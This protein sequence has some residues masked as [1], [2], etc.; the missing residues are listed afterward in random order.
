VQNKGATASPDRHFILS[1]SPPSAQHKRLA[2]ALVIAIAVAALAIAGPLSR[3]ELPRIDAFVPAYATAM[4]VT[5]LITAILLYAQFSILHSRAILVIASGY[6]FSALILIP[7]ILTFPDALRPGQI[8]GGLQS[9]SWL[10]FLQHACF[11]IFVIAYALTK[12][13]TVGDLRSRAP[14]LSSI[15]ASAVSVVLL[16]VAAVAMFVG[17]ASALPRVVLDSV[18]LAPLW[19]YVAA[20]VSLVSVAAIAVLWVK[21]HS[22]L[23]LW[24]K[25]VLFL[26]AVEIPLSYYPN[27]ARFSIGWYSVRV[28]GLISG[29]LILVVL[30]H[31][32]ST[33]YKR[34]LDAVTG[35][36]RERAARLMTGDA[37][38]AAIAHEIKQPLTGM[39]I[40]ADAALRFLDRGTP[41]LAGAK[42]ALGRIANDGHRAASIVDGIRGVFKKDARVR[43]PLDVNDLLEEALAVAR[44]DLL[45][46]QISV[47]VETG[48][49]LPQIRGDP[50]Q[51]QQV[52]L[53]LLTNAS[54]AM[55]NLDEPRRLLV[56]SQSIDGENVEV[57]ISDT[58]RG[59]ASDDADRMFNPLFTTKAGGMGMGLSICRSI[60]EAHEGRLW[61]TPNSPRGAVF[62]LSLRGERQVAPAT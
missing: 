14:F 13:D 50:V 48:V 35:Q 4:F 61:M 25:V 24:L 26:Y 20:P 39:I 41:D 3:L 23:D 11:P 1:S 59:I 6:L 43:I 57:S 47:L 62:Q 60:V 29:S 5:D 38:A 56:K 17:G 30:L 42:E 58:G 49:N 21:R 46:H 7:W 2:L 45:G 55:V 33:L 12:D 15:A 32:I 16:I 53:N 40:S 51:L 9:T 18:H 52:L 22:V 31:E 44:S 37:V 10:Y 8:I 27:P 19:P 28:F 34:L 54:D 36:R